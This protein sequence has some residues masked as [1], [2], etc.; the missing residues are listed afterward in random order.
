MSG[1]RASPPEQ[2]GRV[3][4][5]KL[6]T[7]ND[8]ARLVGSTVTMGHPS[9][10]VHFPEQGKHVYGVFIVFRDYYRLYG[11][12]MFYYIVSEKELPGNYLLYRSDESGE[13]VEPSKGIKPGYVAV[14][15]VN[16]REKPNLLDQIEVDDG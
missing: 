16:L 6:K 3:I 11:V 7:L 2:I 5:L 12:P 13:Y 8:L 10:L 15:I 9:Y 4:P 14:P 1:E